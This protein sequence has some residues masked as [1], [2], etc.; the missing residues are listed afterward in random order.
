MTDT[1]HYDVTLPDLRTSISS[2][3]VIGNAD[4]DSVVIYLTRIVKSRPVAEM[5][6]IL[7]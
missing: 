1:V 7:Q 3:R 2:S 6:E 4:S 5:Y